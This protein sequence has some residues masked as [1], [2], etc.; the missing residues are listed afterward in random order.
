MNNK[1]LLIT[2]AIL[3]IAMSLVAQVTGTFTDSRDG[4]VYKTVMIGTQTWMAENLAYKANSGCWAYDN[5]TNNVAKY[6]YLYNWETAKV[7]CPAGW[8]LPSD[9]EWT[10]LTKYLGGEDVAGG[11]LKSINLWLSPNKGATNETGFTALPGGS[12]NGRG[13][14]GDVGNGGHWWSSTEYQK[15]GAWIRRMSYH[16]SNATRSNYY[17]KGGFS[18]RCVKD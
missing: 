18:V 4:K 16:S 15:I 10:I 17:K 12:C 11:K 3:I 9:A 7:V 1:F 14:F 6:G 13:E 2:A 8:H 5:D